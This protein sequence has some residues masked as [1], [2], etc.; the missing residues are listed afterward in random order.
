MSKTSQLNLR[1][2]EEQRA[3]YERAATLEGTTV[4]ALVT[5]AADER[6]QEVLDAHASMTVPR[7]VFDQLLAQLDEPPRPLA[8][9]VLK[10]LA[11]RRFENR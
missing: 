8:P 4:S 10:A 7:D 11:G 6:A 1:V 3:A 9:A 5:G 2:S